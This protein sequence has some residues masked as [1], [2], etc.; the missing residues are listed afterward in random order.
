[1]DEWIDCNFRDVRLLGSKFYDA[2]KLKPHIMLSSGDRCDE[3]RCVFTRILK[4]L[5][6]VAN[7]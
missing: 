7:S 5:K 3:E 4:A 6:P 2:C 1:M